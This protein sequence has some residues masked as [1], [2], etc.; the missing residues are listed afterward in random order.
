MAAAQD[1]VKR[2]TAAHLLKH[3]F[4]ETRAADGRYA[5]F[6]RCSCTA[7]AQPQRFAD[8]WNLGYGAQVRRPGAPDPD[9]NPAVRGSA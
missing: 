9:G 1:P 8:D 3:P 5:C 2:P 4:L 6:A 7:A